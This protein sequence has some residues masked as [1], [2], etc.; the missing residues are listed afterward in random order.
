MFIFS[1]VAW[2]WK[3]WQIFLLSKNKRIFSPNC[4]MIRDITTHAFGRIRAE[5]IRNRGIWDEIYTVP[6]GPH[7]GY[8]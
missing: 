6:A 5:F 1:M 3:R 2:G 4:G 7:C 8:E